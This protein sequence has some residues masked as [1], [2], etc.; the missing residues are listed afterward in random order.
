M[1]KIMAAILVIAF[2]FILF[3]FNSLDFFRYTDDDNINPLD[4]YQFKAGEDLDI[5]PIESI[6][7]SGSEASSY[8][9]FSNK[10]LFWYNGY[11]FVIEV[12]EKNYDKFIDYIQGY[13]SSNFAYIPF[14][15]HLCRVGTFVSNST[16]GGARAEFLK[17]QISSNFA[18][19]NYSSLGYTLV[20]F[21]Y[22][23]DYFPDTDAGVILGGFDD[24]EGFVSWIDIFPIE[25]VF[26]G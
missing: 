21:Y 19:S 15:F 6:C 25:Y 14:P 4:L 1:K 12:L 7:V 5:W 20:W 23:G 22:E 13:L 8:L 10:F 2:V 11:Y 16:I 3:K 18:W 9:C 24:C 26:T 17:R